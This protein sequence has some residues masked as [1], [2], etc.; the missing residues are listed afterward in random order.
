VCSGIITLRTTDHRKVVQT[1]EFV[2]SLFKALF[3]FPAS[4]LGRALA[5][6]NHP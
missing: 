5:L 4:D 2:N 1:A 6:V 3:E